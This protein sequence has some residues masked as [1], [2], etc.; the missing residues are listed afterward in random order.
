MLEE[1]MLLLESYRFILGIQCLLLT[2][3]PLHSSSMP[4]PRLG[5]S[6]MTVWLHCKHVVFVGKH[7][8]TGS[9]HS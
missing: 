2:T 8:H 9:A 1:L 7:S 3:D 6:G 5:V 4:F